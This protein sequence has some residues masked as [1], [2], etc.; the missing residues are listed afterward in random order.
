MTYGRLSL[1]WGHTGWVMIIPTYLQTSF[2][3]IVS[4]P[5]SD[6]SIKH[7]KEIRRTLNSK[8]YKEHT[9]MGPFFL[10]LALLAVL[11]TLFPFFFL[12]F[13][14]IVIFINIT[15]IVI[16]STSYLNR[17]LQRPDLDNNQSCCHP[18]DFHTRTHPTSQLSLILPVLPFIIIMI[19]IFIII[20]SP[21]C[22]YHQ[23][24][25]KTL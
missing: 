24:C 14:L 23:Y 15:I 2:S 5:D 20:I 11:I 21:T 1:T 17:C 8:L 22:W 6:N 7:A 4:S 18:L 12:V 13:F 25:S 16:C 9:S 10:I 3:A 19:K